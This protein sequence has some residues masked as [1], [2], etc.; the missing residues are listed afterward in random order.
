TDSDQLVCYGTELKQ[1]WNLQLKN[2]KLAFAPSKIGSQL[3]IAYQDGKFLILNP[4]TGQEINQFSVDQP[5][6]NEPLFFNKRLYLTGLDG[7]LHVVDFE[8]VIQ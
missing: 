8:K 3:I 1:K 4:S 6:V 5:I 7:T 2:I